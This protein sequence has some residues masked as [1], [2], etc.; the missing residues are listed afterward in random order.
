[1]ELKSTAERLNLR[2][3]RKT[4]KTKTLVKKVLLHLVFQ[5]VPSQCKRTNTHSVM[6][7]KIQITFDMQILI[8]RILSLK[9]EIY[10]NCV[11][12]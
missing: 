7:I 1:M 12:D 4:W 8:V 10:L 3:N 5:N 6:N 9:N 11:F 2:Q